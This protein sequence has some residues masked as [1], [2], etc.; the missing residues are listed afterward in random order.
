MK[1]RNLIALAA[2]LCLLQACSHPIEIVG[3]GDVSSDQGRSCSLED[4]QLGADDC[5]VNLVYSDYLLTYTAEPRPGWI[6]DRWGNYCSDATDNTCSFDIPEEAVRKYWGQTAK[7]L[8][9]V[10]SK[11]KVSGPILPAN[12]IILSTGDPDLQAYAKQEFFLEGSATSYTPELPLPDD[13]KLV[14]S[15]NPETTDGNYKTRLVVLRPLDKAKFNGTVIVEWLNVTAGADVAQ[16]WTYAHN[17][18]IRSGY[19]WIGV[20]AQ[21]R[22][23][24]FLVQRPRYASLVHPGD[25][26]SYDIFSD[27]GRAVQE[28]AS[29]LLGG[30]S[31]E[32]LIA[33]GESQSASR[34]VT[35]INAVH[36]LQQIFDGF[37]VHSRGT[38]G[39]SISQ[40]PLPSYPYEAAAAPIRDDLAVP[41]MVV[42]AENDMVRSN[43]AN[44]QPD[45]S[46]FRMW[47]MA[48]T[49]HA[50][51]YVLSGLTD[52]GD[53]EG[54]AQMF[55]FL[56]S[57]INPLGCDK[58][59][60]AGAQHWILQAAYD[61]LDNWIRTLQDPQLTVTPPPVGTPLTVVSD[62]PV[63]LAR[64]AQGNAL[65]GIRSP[66]VDAPVALLE[67]VNG[68]GYTFCFLFGSTTP[69]TPEE[70]LQLYPTRDDFITQWN[71]SILTNVVNGF[72][73]PADAQELVDAAAGWDFPN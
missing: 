12:Q 43:L 54:A 6:F 7:P 55:G 51:A 69:F 13:G 39:S 48:G 34:M 20:S 18:F 41:V 44:R 21:A 40:S 2:T 19:A 26:Y 1:L 17:E 4:F 23:V 62:T 24:D 10:F 53:G 28:A 42:Q 30:L 64:D 57:P 38:L 50:D 29:V 67:G 56:R 58:P 5:A 22:G 52:I 46:L 68:G 3:E 66:Q 47:E 11:Y 27:S 70:I 61:G 36:P 63:I 73:L 14:V 71:S 32:R 35:Y 16:E 25:S 37:M 15:A 59:V 65:G 33:A 49:A 9:A 72:L 45:T 8:Q 31:V 60:N